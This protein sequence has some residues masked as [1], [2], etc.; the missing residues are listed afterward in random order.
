MGERWAELVNLLTDLR[1]VEVKALLG[2]TYGL[3]DDYN[4][5][6]RDGLKYNG[7]VRRMR[8]GCFL[9]Y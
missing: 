2:L 3:I 5:A 4:E 1:F 6:C 8:L 9:K 7:K